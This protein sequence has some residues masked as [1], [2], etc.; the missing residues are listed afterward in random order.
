MPRR[1]FTLIE[2]FL[3]IFVG[4]ILLAI[5]LPFFQPHTSPGLTET[6]RR[7]ENA[8]R[9]YA[10]QNA[11][12]AGSPVPLSVLILSLPAPPDGCEF[13][14]GRV[15]EPVGLKLRAGS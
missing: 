12:P 8:K 7:L 1:A 6:L 9:T 11:L 4:S 5:A 15:G 14:P 13:D 3:A 2:L 10:E